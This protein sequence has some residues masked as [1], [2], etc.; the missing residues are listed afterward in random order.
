MLR[1][2]NVGLSVAGVMGVLVIFN[3]IYAADPEVR[4]ASCQTA[5]AGEADRRLAR[6]WPDPP[7]V[8]PAGAAGRSRP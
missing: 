8:W 3:L 4:P 7:G 6:L 2:Q 1:A 5:S